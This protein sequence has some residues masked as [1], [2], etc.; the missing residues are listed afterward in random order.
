MIKKV[1]A[2]ALMLIALCACG[3]KPEDQI[4]PVASVTLSQ[5]EAEMK[6][7]ETLQLKAQISPSNA[8]EQKVMWGSSK[9]SVATV[10]DAGLVTAVAAG[11]ANITATVDG[12]SATCK[13]TVVKPENPVVPV[14]SIKLDKTEASLEIGQSLTLTATVLP[15]TATDKTVE[16][17]SSAPAS[18]E[19]DQNGKVTAISE[20]SARIT[21]SAG[22]KT[23]TC[24]IT[25][26]TPE[27]PVVHVESVTLDRT[28]VQLEIGQTLALTAT[29]LPE[30]AADKAVIW[31]STNPSIARVDERGNVTAVSSGSVTV[32]VTTTDGGKIAACEVT[33]AAAQPQGEVYDGEEN[34]HYWVDLGLPSG[35]KWATRNV[36][37]PS[38]EDYGGYYAWGETSTKS[39]FSTENYSVQGKYSMGQDNLTELLPADDVAHIVMG[40]N[41]YIPTREEMQELLDNC[42]FERIDMKNG[43]GYKVVSKRNGKYFL[44][45][46]AGSITYDVEEYV[47]GVFF[48]WTSSVRAERVSEAWNLNTYNNEL[49]VDGRVRFRGCP[50]RA[51]TGRPVVSV[52]SVSLDQTQAS[53]YPDGRLTLTATV[54][55]ANA[56]DISVVWTSSNPSVAEVDQSGNVTA[57]SVGTATITVTTNDGGKKATCEVT[58][59]ERT[60]D[61]VPVASV[62]ISKTS[63]GLR[64]GES[65]QLSAT[66]LPEN[67]TD[68]SVRWESSNPSI[69]GVDQTGYVTAYSVGTTTVTVTTTDGGKIAGC[70]V[71]V[72][73][74]YVP[75]ESVTILFDGR[76]CYAMGAEKGM[77]HQFSAQVLPVNASNKLVTWTSS[78][79]NVATV[80]QTGQVMFVGAGDAVITAEA[81][82][83]T[84]ECSVGVYVQLESI[85]LD[86]D[87]LSMK[88]GE[89]STLVATLHPDDATFREVYWESSNPNVVTVD[90]GKLVAVAAGESY[91]KAYYGPIEALC[92]VTVTSSTVPAQ[93]VS[94]DFPYLMLGR[95]REE[96]VTAT[97]SPSNSTDHVVWSITDPEIATIN[98]TTGRVKALKKGKT[99][100][101]AT[102]GE[103]SSSI[104]L[105]V[106]VP[107]ERIDLDLTEVELPE[108]GAVNLHATVFPEDADESLV[109]WRSSDETVAT[110]R[111]SDGFVRA[112]SQ[113][114]A[115]IEAFNVYSGVSTV[116][117]VTVVPRGAPAI[118]LTQN[119]FTIEADQTEDIAI[120]YRIENSVS[121][122]S[123]EVSVSP[124]AQDWL[125]TRMVGRVTFY[126]IKNN[127]YQ[128]RTGQITFKYGEATAVVTVTQK[129]VGSS[130]P[131]DI[132]FD[133]LIDPEANNGIN[134]SG[135]EETVFYARVVNPV[136]GVNLEMNADV[137]W[138]TNIRPRTD[139]NWY[140]FTASQNTTGR[141]RTGHVVLTYGSVTKTI[142][143]VQQAG[144]VTI[145]LN[146]GDMTVNYAA[147]T[148]S[149]EVTLPDGYDY[150]ELTAELDDYISWVT[151]VA[152]S[153]RTVSFKVKENN[154]SSYPTRSARIK[155]SLGDQ[156]SYFNV[157]QTY[158]APVM[159]VLHTEMTLSYERQM[160]PIPVNITNPRATGY[161]DVQIPSGYGWIYASPADENGNPQITVLA[162]ETG[163]DRT[164]TLELS[165]GSSTAT[166]RVTQTSSSTTI[167]VP[168]SESFGWQGITYTTTILITDPLQYESLEVSPDVPWIK[169]NSIVEMSSTQVAVSLII[170]KN[171]TG[172]ARTGN[173]VFTYAHVTKTMVV[174]QEANPNIP[175]GFI[176]LGLA[177]G[178]LWAEKNLGAANYYNNGNYYAWGEIT[179]K[180]KYTWFNYKW[181]SGSEPWNNITKYN[182]T[183]GKRELE[184]ADDAATVANSHWTIPTV[185]QWS[186][187]LDQC[188]LVWVLSP[189]PG[190]MIYDQDEENYIFLPAAGNKSDNDPIETY[191]E[192]WSKSMNNNPDVQVFVGEEDGWYITN[193]TRYYGVPIRPVWKQ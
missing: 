104:E 53:L 42:T 125:R 41:W 137:P 152:I 159:T 73:A 140:C 164:V 36:G 190:Y 183:D 189:V 131:A 193:G 94:I 144:D 7:G 40:G 8:T 33:V 70:E 46:A 114:T 127:S 49:V 162:N 146:P 62:T 75:V 151:D 188:S 100:I 66:V 88:V 91:I 4:V 16:W 48:Y 136:E 6:V 1:F 93:S 63:L 23:A 18:V 186:E 99:T 166:V 15:D 26:T 126:A 92:H 134:S 20:G 165:Y 149:F 98:P 180:S 87:V 156:A 27:V 121:G 50:V 115:Q 25:V 153:G 90:G 3:E 154:N 19:V 148:V 78:N 77:I 116:C 175:D 129:G 160:V 185:D 96:T 82:G 67:A 155:V 52:E 174:S 56:A 51:V 81:G 60:P 44:L 76:P 191:C 111:S 13:I 69:A 22:G 173:V 138:I 139:E 95:G 57:K 85:T 58:V 163:S 109:L 142:K 9:Q 168:E 117:N 65:Y 128:S 123:L 47:G 120:P 97:V 158:D 113:G 169:V 31:Q 74:V 110:V 179:T 45:P 187:L 118:V 103:K 150:N 161:V 71:S 61:V 39:N 43:S 157:N 102:A 84:F 37:A 12:K 177:S 30:N 106:W 38:P 178:T 145:I 143:F 5:P 28:D 29:V 124:S 86:R 79:T 64:P 10:S 107:V 34:G 14:E 54:L 122:T 192:Y 32:T 170:K 68:K 130:G 176:D 112:V 105:T 72:S 135:E 11:T 147:Q 167:T 21:A 24:Q 172:R 35:I 133:G 59:I 101:V 2:V 141:E 80:D 132:V 119:S 182:K 184:P 108:G 83:K 17:Q 171:R 181:A 55:P 89:S